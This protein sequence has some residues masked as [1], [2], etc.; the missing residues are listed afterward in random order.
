MKSGQADAGV[1]DK[2]SAETYVKN[3]PGAGLVIAEGMEY[4]L[5]DHFTGYRVAAKKGEIQLIYFVNGVINEVTASGTYDSWLDE[6]AK[7]AEELGM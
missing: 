5:E 7:R 6:A 1:V 4:Q 2:K 3:N